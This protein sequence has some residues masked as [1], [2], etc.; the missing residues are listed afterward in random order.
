MDA[1]PVMKYLKGKHYNEYALQPLPPRR[2]QVMDLCLLRNDPTGSLRYSQEEGL[3]KRSIE[4][5][6]QT[7]Y[8]TPA[9]GTPATAAKKAHKKSSFRSGSKKAAVREGR[10]DGTTADEGADSNVPGAAGAG[11]AGAA[12]VGGGAAGGEERDSTADMCAICLVE[13]ENGDELRIIPNCDHHFHKV[14]VLAG[15][16]GGDLCCCCCCC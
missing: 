7:R 4:R 5:L 2:L 3:P 6:P 1:W 8:K 15:G 14:C 13:Y 12:V 11:T 16:E 9:S 10:A